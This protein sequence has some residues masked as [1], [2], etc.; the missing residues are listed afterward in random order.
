MASSQVRLR[1]LPSAR[2]LFDKTVQIR[3]EGLSPHKPLMLRSKVVDDRGIVFKATAQYRADKLGCV[4]VSQAASLGGSYTGVE[5]MGLFWS[6]LPETPHSKLVMKTALNPMQVEISALDE[7]NGGEVLASEINYREFMAEG[8]KRIPLTEGRLRG[9][10]FVPPGPGP[11]PAIVDLYTLGGR[12]SEPRASL[13]ASKGFVT[14]ALAYQDYQDLPKNPKYVELEYF[15]EAVKYLL[16]LPEVKGPGVGII[17]ISN[18]G[19]IALA[20]ASFLD[21]IAATVWINGCI[22][23]IVIPLRYKDVHLP[24]LR[25]IWENL[26]VL[27][28]GLLDISRGLAD[29]QEHKESLIPIERAT[30]QFLF[31]ASGDDYNWASV[32]FA[33]QAEA[34]L[35]KHNK[36]TCSVVVYPKAGHFLEMPPMPFCPSAVHAAV[37]KAVY[38]GGEAKANAEAQVDLWERV[39]QFFK[40]HLGAEKPLSSNL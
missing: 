12:L 5:P 6:M 30:S 29:P 2:C 22:S 39:Q 13:L 35:K 15:E 16:S 18:G 34:T 3:V 28:S 32:P 21:N 11:F 20:M 27:E 36:N 14:M 23:A 4:D 25:L 37:G 10:L 8:V 19:F 17:S 40:T 31:A 9:T 7:G 38:F 26:K 24:A 33:K 1:I